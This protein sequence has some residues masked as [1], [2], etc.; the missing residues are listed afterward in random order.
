MAYTKM[1]ETTLL[2]TLV[3]N[4]YTNDFHGNFAIKPLSHVKLIH[5]T[6]LCYGGSDHLFQQG[7]SRWI[8]YSE[9]TVRRQLLQA[10][11]PVQRTGSGIASQKRIVLQL[12][13]ERSEDKLQNG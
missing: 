10:G 11:K 6:Q 13:K 5:D 1:N 7:G 3:V 12:K 4:N 9:S 8:R 2:R